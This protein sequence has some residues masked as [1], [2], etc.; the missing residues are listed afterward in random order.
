MKL[1]YA[2][3]V[4][5]VFLFTNS[6]FAQE[7]TTTAM[8]ANYSVEII[9][10]SIA[11]DQRSKFEEAYASAGKILQLSPYCL[12]YEVIKGVDEPQR[13]VVRI[14]WTSLS[15]HLNGFRK[16]KEFSS[17]FNLVRP[18]YNAIDEMKHYETTST[19]WKKE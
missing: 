6:I 12:H 16:S 13:Y 15:D 10:Y 7:K 4:G 9:R 18:F 5:I 17:F 1:K 19:Q 8:N 11:E 2:A 3:S 14:H